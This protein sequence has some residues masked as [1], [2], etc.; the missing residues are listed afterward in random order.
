M[1]AD[2]EADTELSGYASYPQFGSVSGTDTP[3]SV[4][5]LSHY[6]SVASLAESVRSFEEDGT[7]FNWKNEQRRG[8][9]VR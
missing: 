9:Y 4:G 8:S 1:N 7:P 5:G 6:G 2:I 3:S